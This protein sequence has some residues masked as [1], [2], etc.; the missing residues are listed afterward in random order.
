MLKDKAALITG[1]TGSFGDGFVPM[2]LAK[3]NPRR[4]VIFSRDEMKQWGMEKIYG[5]DLRIRFF[6]GDVQDKYRLH[7]TLT[8]I[9]YV[10]HAAASRIVSAADHNPSESFK[11]NINDEMSLIDV[12]ID[13]GVRRVLALLTDKASSI[14]L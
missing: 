8:E 12:C 14:E 1:V 3:Y 6:I 7:R 2:T 10:I 4:L 11:T 5:H 13:Q 9:D